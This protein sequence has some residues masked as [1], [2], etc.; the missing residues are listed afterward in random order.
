M[1]GLRQV[2]LTPIMT[3]FIMSV[4]YDNN[5]TE[6][7]I[8]YFRFQPENTLQEICNKIT[9]ETTSNDYALLFN[10]DGYNLR[11]V[12]VITTDYTNMPFEFVFTD[13]TQAP[14]TLRLISNLTPTVSFTHV[15]GIQ[16]LMIR[17]SII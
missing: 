14:R 1:I 11:I 2:K 6:S 17:D 15:S 4:S 8:T 13:N 16:P 7:K 5:K 12:A 3:N 9:E 10:F